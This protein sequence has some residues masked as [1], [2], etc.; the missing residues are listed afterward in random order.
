M[1]SISGSMLKALSAPF[2][3][4]II[5][6]PH[7]AASAPVDN[8]TFEKVQNKTQ[9]V[10][11]KSHLGTAHPNINKDVYVLPHGS[12]VL[13]P[14]SLENKLL[15]AKNQNASHNKVK[16]ALDKQRK[17]SNIYLGLGFGPTGL[18]LSSD[19]L[20][21]FQS[22]RN[23]VT[24]NGTSAISPTSATG[25]GGDVRLGY[26]FKHK[27]LHIMAESFYTTSFMNANIPSVY[28]GG[29]TL[30][31]FTSNI[32]FKDLSIFGVRLK[33]G[34]NLNINT[35]IYP[36]I[37]YGEAHFKMAQVGNP[38]R[39]SS[40]A[41]I[42]GVGLSHYLS[43]SVTV[44]VEYTAFSFQS[45]DFSPTPPAYYSATNITSTPAPINMVLH[46]IFLGV[47]FNF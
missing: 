18:N 9:T 40:G 23:S 10:E 35:S 20:T 11:N 39:M 32:N 30:A 4:A 36:I 41:L 1:R 34:L 12:M 27:K 3:A 25:F 6:A 17:I 26:Q 38:E 37:G 5:L 46:S 42:Y 19:A 33:A 24:Q 21:R 47:N 2:F 28:S 22:V 13:L 44:F 8:G 14:P 31:G 16:K 45:K 15:N 29:G 7:L 43:H